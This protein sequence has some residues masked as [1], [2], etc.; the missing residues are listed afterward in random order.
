V[1]L[2]S[3]NGLDL[4]IL[5]VMGFALVRGAFRG[6]IREV[7][8]IVGVVGAYFLAN[9]TYMK[10][11]PAVRDL[12]DNPGT[13]AGVSY[14]IVF[15]AFALLLMLVLRLGEY[16][17]ARSFP[18]GAANHAGGFVVGGLKGTLFVAIALLAL[19]A[20]PEGRTLI[21]ESATAR[22]F[23]PVTRLL[24]DRFAQALHEAPTRPVVPLGPG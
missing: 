11:E 20:A 7:L 24:G 4:G 5:L 16:G 22:L 17:L 15:I 19:G 18:A 21:H 2:P 14:V 1:S 10:V 12:V 13:S 6:L 8:G 9:L 23:L 3:F